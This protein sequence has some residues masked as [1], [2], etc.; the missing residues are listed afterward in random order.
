MNSMHN[1]NDLC[2]GLVVL[3][4]PVGYRAYLK[5]TRTVSYYMYFYDYFEKEN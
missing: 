5:L 4:L 1:T 3:I 2:R